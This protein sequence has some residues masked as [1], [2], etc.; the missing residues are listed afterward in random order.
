M[1][2]I[3]RTSANIR[4]LFC[5]VVFLLSTS[6]ISCFYTLQRIWQTH[7]STLSLVGA[8]GIWASTMVV[9]LVI[10]FKSLTI[11][12]YVLYPISLILFIINTLANAA[13]YQMATSITPSMIHAAVLSPFADIASFITWPQ[14][15]LFSIGILGLIIHCKL[16]SRVCEF[17]DAPAAYGLCATISLLLL[18]SD[19]STAMSDQP[20]FQAV[21][22]LIALMLPSSHAPLMDNTAFSTQD[23]TPR[24]V[25]LVIGESARSDH[26][27]LNGYGRATNPYLTSLPNVV[28]YPNV[29]SCTTLTHTSLT[30]MLTDATLSDFKDSN[31]VVA[32]WGFSMMEG[33]KRANFYT[34][35]IGM[36]GYRGLTP[37]PYLQIA[38]AADMPVFPGAHISFGKP[39]Y[40]EVML[41]YIDTFLKARPEQPKFL[42]IHLY[43][44]HFP[45]DIRYPEQF[46]KF[47]PTC[48]STSE[49]LDLLGNNLK[50]CDKR[51]PNSVTNSYDNSLVY[52]DYVLSRIIDKL[53]S[54]RA[55]LVY[56]SDHGESLGKDGNYTHGRTNV[57]EQRMV[58]MIFWASHSFMQN[59]PNQWKHISENKHTAISHDHVFHSLLNCA[60]IQS[61]RIRDSLSLC[62]SKPNPRNQ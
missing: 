51:M 28:S 54:Q 1:N 36:Q 58:P 5:A 8:I 17:K 30:C 42:V 29:Q 3:N 38:D 7:D 46:K 26:F 34:G 11:R 13:S 56:V 24:T 31:T 55:M 2:A 45:Y 39:P 19:S 32:K 60:G 48:G 22:P 23:H 43:G 57:P 10:L 62:S 49:T 21:K 53:K 52:T 18:F 33:F 14:V 40:D 9:F 61:F 16:L 35:W 6:S 4:L 12:R 41:P 59:Y 25:V 27:Q 15:V 50:D 47:S 20:P 37:I 44:S